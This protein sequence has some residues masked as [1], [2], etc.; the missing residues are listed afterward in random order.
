MSGA[1]SPSI[2]VL[3]FPCPTCSTAVSLDLASADAT[4]LFTCSCGYVR[5]LGP[6]FPSLSAIVAQN[7]QFDDTTIRQ[8]VIDAMSAWFFEWSAPD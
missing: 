4:T 5:A 8:R 7:Q 3:R 1:A 6:Q 2:G